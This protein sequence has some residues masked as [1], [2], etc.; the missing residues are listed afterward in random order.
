MQTAHLKPGPGRRVRDPRR[1]FA[2]IPPE[3]YP[4]PLDEFAR[5]RLSDGD[6][7]R[8]VPPRPAPSSSK[9]AAKKGKD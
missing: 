6:L 2:V 8:V 5:R 3:G 4:M 1:R 9:A 7:V